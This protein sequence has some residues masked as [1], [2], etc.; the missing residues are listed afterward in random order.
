MLIYIAYTFAVSPTQLLSSKIK[1]QNYACIE[2][3]KSV[4][5]TLQ[6]GL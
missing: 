6:K 4:G 1:E 2:H 3:S 5:L